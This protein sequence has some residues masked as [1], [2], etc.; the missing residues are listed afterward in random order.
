MYHAEFPSLDTPSLAQH[1]PG[2]AMAS[3][4]IVT[5]GKAGPSRER[6]ATGES[7]QRRQQSFSEWRLEKQA[8]NP[9]LSLRAEHSKYHLIPAS[10]SI[11]NQ[12]NRIGV[13]HIPN[14]MAALGTTRSKCGVNPP[15]KE[16]IPSSLKIVVKHCTSPV[17]FSRPS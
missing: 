11:W 13:T 16:A 2:R 6:N 7:G 4:R 12:P 15:Y 10:S 14:M 5:S 1:A 3:N 17:Y 8:A 9:L